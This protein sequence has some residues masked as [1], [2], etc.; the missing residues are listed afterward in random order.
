MVAMR[1]VN[2]VLTAIKSVRRRA[3][4]AYSADDNDKLL[5]LMKDLIALQLCL[6]IEIEKVK[7][8]LKEIA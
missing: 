2:D 4:V 5:S 6:E 7:A 8:E 1:Y 3:M